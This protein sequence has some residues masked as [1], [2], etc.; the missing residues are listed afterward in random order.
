[1]EISDDRQFVDRLLA[2]DEAAFRRLMDDQ[3]QRLYRFAVTRTG[4][5]SSAAEDIVQN[6]VC[7]A[8]ENLPTYRGEA[9]FLAWLF[10]ICRRELATWYRAQKRN[11]DLWLQ[12]ED[13]PMVQAAL[14]SI[15][16]SGTDY[17]AEAL[18]N[19]QIRRVVH[20]TLDNLPSHYA[21]VLQWRYI[22][23]M[24]VR[25]TARNLGISVKA[26]ESLLIRAKAAFREAFALI[27]GAHGDLIDLQKD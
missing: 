5:D 4:N 7:K 9:S 20:V 8:I 26:A 22:H 13:A 11:P 16:E 6:A 24:S 18:Q 1:M 15:Y 2:G 19:D 14:A 17:P 3:V 23:S 21:N 10:G 27:V 12:P 25:E